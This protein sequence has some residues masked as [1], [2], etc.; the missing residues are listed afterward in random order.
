MNKQQETFARIATRLQQAALHADWQELSEADR[1][2]ADLLTPYLG[3]GQLGAAEL[4]ALMVLRKVHDDAFERCVEAGERISLRLAELGA[5]RDG[6]L[7]YAH[8]REISGEA[9]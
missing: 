1:E 8:D 5:A 6:W 2:L 7:A 4:S 9:I 3:R